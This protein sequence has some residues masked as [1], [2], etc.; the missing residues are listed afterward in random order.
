[1][2][3][4]SNGITADVIRD[5]MPPYQ[6]NADLV[7]A[8]LASIRPPP[9]GASQA[10]RQERTAR[11]IDEIT[12]LTPADAA[13]ARIASQIVILREE[14]D[15]TA[16]RGF[17]PGLTLEQAC[18]LRRTGAVLVNAVAMLERML[19]RHQQMPVPFFGTVLMDGVDVAALAAGWGGEEE[20]VVTEEDEGVA[21]GDGG[22]STDAPA[23]AAMAGTSPAMT[24]L[25]SPVMTVLS[26]PVEAV[27]SS[28]AVVVSS[29]PAV[30]VSSG[31]VAA[32]NSDPAVTVSSSLAVAVNS[33]PAVAVSPGPV[34]TKK[35]WGPAPGGVTRLDQG[36]GWT[37][38][39]VRSRTVGGVASDGVVGDE[40][41]GAAPEL[42][43]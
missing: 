43:G 5:L 33:Q 32:A 37:L 6:L 30:V 11:L 35:G 41:I 23:A 8:T 14:K 9:P 28:P 31:P 25:S 21:V 42:V 39:V 3:A 15:D 27:S 34:V 29:G 17:A 18:R 4:P 26:S 19:V 22:G 24:V 16:A 2:T 36:P 10:W 1:M 40:A 20:A 13:Q 38:D 12:A 7:A